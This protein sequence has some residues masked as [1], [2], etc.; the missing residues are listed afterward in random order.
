MLKFA[1]LLAIFAKATAGIGDPSVAKAIGSTYVK[2][3]TSKT[4]TSA[5]NGGGSATQFIFDGTLFKTNDGS[6]TEDGLSEEIGTYS[7]TCTTTTVTTPQNYYCQ[8]TDKF[9]DGE[10]ALQGSGVLDGSDGVFAIVGG[11]GRY[12]GA[13]GTMSV[14]TLTE[15]VFE[16]KYDLK[17]RKGRGKPGRGKPGRG[18]PGRGKPGRGK[19][20]RGNPG[21]RG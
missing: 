10:I 13:E 19:P 17:K 7:G 15:V 12:S 6:G 11:T 21:R 16:H 5:V 1:I 14:I 3:S 4:I 8:I 20:G 9:E 18:K 2:G